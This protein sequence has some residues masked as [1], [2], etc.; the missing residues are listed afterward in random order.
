M[1]RIKMI[2]SNFNVIISVIL[3]T[4]LTALVGIWAAR[5]TTGDLRNFYLADGGLRSWGAA[6][7]GAASS[8]SG[9]VLL[10]LVGVAYSTGI[11]A[12]WLVPG[13]SLGY[14]FNWF[15]LAPRLRK[16]TQETQAITIIDLFHAKFGSSHI[17]RYLTSAII[18]I[19]LGAYI[20]A[21]F[22]AVGKA[23][24]SMFGLKYIIGVIIGITLVL[25]YTARGG[26][27]SSVWTD[28][29]QSILMVGTLIG[30][31]ILAF[32]TFEGNV[33]SV[34]DKTSHLFD[35]TGG[36]TGMASLGF[37]A[38]WVGIGLAYPGQPHVL[39][40]IMAVRDDKELYKAGFIAILWSTLVFLGAIATGLVA[41]LWIPSLS[42][43][44]TALP[45]LALTILSAPLAGIVL[46]A[47]LAAI[48]STADSQLLVV[49]STIEHDLYKKAKQK[50]SSMMRVFL[51]ISVAL[52]AGL[53][54]ITEIRV[55]FTFVLY[56]WGA[57]G[58]S[59]GPA[60]IAMLFWPRTSSQGVIIG[61]ISGLITLVVWKNT[62]IL[63]STVYELIPAFVISL[64]TMRFVKR[65]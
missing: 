52:I 12:L 13:A 54:A 57:L 10:G 6:L 40:R 33:T 11:S 28:I 44:E 51:V 19:F 15:I 7:S 2:G 5:R 43:P 49:C 20:A 34:F 17:L 35:F 31:P 30:L 45:Q 58:V 25:S 32:L 63:S 9:W 60:I 16:S 37:I 56:A 53:V 48:C 39:T 47:V 65:K 50:K 14:T 36:S 55:I 27:R 4:I 24:S 61:M 23:L 42:D 22:T 59:I 1:W 46:A 8:E 26:L 21:Q 29:I 3:Y 18:I 62:T 38:G 64:F 41:H